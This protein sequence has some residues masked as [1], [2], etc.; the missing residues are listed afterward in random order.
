MV[1]S[2]V[3]MTKM[4][5]LLPHTFALAV[6][7]VAFAHLNSLADHKGTQRGRLGA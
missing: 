2:N 5:L 1:D 3:M 6:F 7:R 4:A